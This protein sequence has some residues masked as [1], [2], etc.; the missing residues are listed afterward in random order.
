MRSPRCQSCWPASAALGGSW[1]DELLVLLGFSGRGDKDL[2]ALERFV[3]VASWG[4]G[5]DTTQDCDRASS[6]HHRGARPCP[7]ERRPDDRR[8]AHRGRVRSRPRRK[9]H[10]ADPLRGGRLSRCRNQLRDRAR[11]RRLGRRPTGGGP[12]RSRTRWPTVRR[13]SARPGAPLRRAP[14]SS[15]RSGSIERI[16]AARPDL[17]LVPMAYANQV[18]GGGDGEAVA[19]RLAGAGAAG[20]IVADLT[21]DEGAP[22][23]AVA[24]GG[25]LGGRLPRRARR[26]RPPGAPGSRRAAAGSS[27]ASPSSA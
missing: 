3:D 13:S 22:F 12:A 5:S 17:P 11:G 2:A 27:T 15:A 19:R 16:G 6:A 14:P 20:L 18:I 4:A 24:A 25:G 10:R 9:P 7:T 26:P 8:P 21:P 23:E 1:P